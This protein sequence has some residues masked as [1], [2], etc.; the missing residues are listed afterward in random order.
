MPMGFRLKKYIFYV[1]LT[2]ACVFTQYPKKRDK[3]IWTIS[4]LFFFLQVFMVGFFPPLVNFFMMKVINRESFG[5][6]CPEL[7]GQMVL[8]IQRGL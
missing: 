1:Q 8:G 5:M 2:R 7:G 4:K 3:T 6:V